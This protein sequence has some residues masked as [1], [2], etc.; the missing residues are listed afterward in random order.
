MNTCTL[1]QFS[2]AAAESDHEIPADK[3][4]TKC[5]KTGWNDCLEQQRKEQAESFPRLP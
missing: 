4:Q 1:L 3:A 5:A 2:V